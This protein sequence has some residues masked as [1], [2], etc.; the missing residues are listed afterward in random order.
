[1]HTEPPGAIAVL[2]SSPTRSIAMAEAFST[3]SREVIR[4]FE[5]SG[6]IR[7][8][9]PDA[10]LDN[11]S[12]CLCHLGDAAKLYRKVLAPRKTV[13]YGADGGND[14]RC[15][16]G[17][18]RIWHRVE[19]KFGALKSAEA[20]QLL[21][22]AEGHGPKPHLLNRT[23]PAPIQSTLIILCQGYLAVHAA[24][25]TAMAST[26][27]QCDFDM[28][29]Y[30]S[31]MLAI[32]WSALPSSTRR[33]YVTTLPL[34]LERVRSVDWWQRPYLRAQ[35]RAQ[36]EFIA[37]RFRASVE[38][39]WKKNHP[40]IELDSAI[41]ALIDKI[42]VVQGEVNIQAVAAAYKALTAQGEGGQQQ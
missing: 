16:V 23:E 27:E 12:L 31:E 8:S 18:E 7:T 30:R 21:K 22:Y 15:P 25:A 11:V 24:V 35:G 13:Y 6:H 20:V 3:T 29:E 34:Q 32:G 41:S 17:A 9:P 37:S 36:E 1:M 19:G 38:S 26:G 39:E 5:E 33:L 2:D 14:S 42:G 28:Q 40:G 4:C 10:K